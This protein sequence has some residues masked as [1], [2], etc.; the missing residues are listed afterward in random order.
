MK[1][2]L[3]AFFL[4]LVFVGTGQLHAQG[5]TG[6]DPKDI[7]LASEQ[8]NG[9]S[10]A[11][12]NLL[13]VEEVNIAFEDGN[14]RPNMSGCYTYNSNVHFSL[15]TDPNISF[16]MSSTEGHQGIPYG[17]GNFSFNIGGLSLPCNSE[18]DLGFTAY[19]TLPNGQTYS[20]CTKWWYF[21]CM[22]CPDHE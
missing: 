15:P 16:S 22:N 20:V 12:C 4:L 21:L 17:N 5:G 19:A 7:C 13:T 11:F 14:C 10:G 6:S 1:Y 8:A 9:E 3:I 2:K 18:L